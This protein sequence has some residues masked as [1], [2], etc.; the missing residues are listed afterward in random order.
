MHHHESVFFCINLGWTYL[1][2]G[3]GFESDPGT[4]QPFLEHLESRIGAGVIRLQSVCLMATIKSV[5][6]QCILF[7]VSCTY[8]HLSKESVEQVAQ[9]AF[10]ANEE[11]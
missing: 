2:P 8:V 5:M 11:I 10:A 3:Y 4:N 9:S 7:L 1:G 6:R